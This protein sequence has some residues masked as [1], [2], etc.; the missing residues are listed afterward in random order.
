MPWIKQKE[1]E[2]Y[3][4]LENNL[5]SSSTRNSAAMEDIAGSTEAIENVNGDILSVDNGSVA[6]DIN[7]SP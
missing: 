3:N 7:T 2:L 6:E 4:R 1:M 5:K